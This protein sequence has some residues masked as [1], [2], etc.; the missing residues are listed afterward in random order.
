MFV[1][2]KDRTLW[3]VIDYWKLNNIMEDDANK[4][5]Y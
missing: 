1:L 4:A 3:M 2:K 5:L